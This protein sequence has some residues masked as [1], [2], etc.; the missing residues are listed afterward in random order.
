MYDDNDD[1]EAL[2]DEYIHNNNE[3]YMCEEQNEDGLEPP[4]DDVSFE[5]EHNNEVGGST[6]MVDV[7]GMLEQPHSQLQQHQQHQKHPAP[8]PDILPVR[9]DVND[10]NSRNKESPMDHG[11]PNTTARSNQICIALKGTFFALQLHFSFHSFVFH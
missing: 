10:T 7:Q 3:D 1:D 11:A 8:E 4:E 9:H 6:T 2:I 5:N